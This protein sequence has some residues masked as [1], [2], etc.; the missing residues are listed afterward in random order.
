MFYSFHTVTHYYIGK[1]EKLYPS[2]AQLTNA[3]EVYETGP[4]DPHYSKKG[5][6]KSFEKVPDHTLVPVGAG[7][8]IFP[9]PAQKEP[10]KSKT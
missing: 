10:V 4:L 2:H 3:V 1:L 9:W 5:E 7:T 6:A 8:I